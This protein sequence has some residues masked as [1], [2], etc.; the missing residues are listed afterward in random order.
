M[1]ISWDV[2]FRPAYINWLELE[3]RLKIPVYER[4]SQSIAAGTPYHSFIL[5][6]ELKFAQGFD[7]QCIRKNLPTICYNCHGLTF[8]T[9]RGWLND[10]D[11]VF[12]N[13]HYDELQK[14][15]LI[16]SGDIISYLE[17]VNGVMQTSHTGVIVENASQQTYDQVL[18]PNNAS[19]K[20][21]SKWGAHGEYLHDHE[22]SP[23]GT[24]FKVFRYQRSHY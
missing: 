24:N 21:L 17:D 12:N 11:L 18:Q 22:K 9:R 1:H 5:Q 13:E 7:S 14:N 3:S 4:F 19:L 20:V 2:Y 6:E 16:L 23:Y 8:A 10:V 15:E